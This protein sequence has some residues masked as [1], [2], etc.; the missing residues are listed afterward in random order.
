M[1][2]C[3]NSSHDLNRGLSKS[4]AR[5]P[6]R[7]LWVSVSG[8]LALML[9]A[10]MVALLEQTAHAKGCTAWI[11]P[12]PVGDNTNEGT[13]DEPWATLEH[14]ARNV[15]DEGC[16][17]WVE[18]GTYY[19][20]T[21]F[22]RRFEQNVT[23]KAAEPYEVI[24][25]NRG[26]VLNFDGALNVT[27]EGFV[28]R[29]S[30]PGAGFQVIKIDRSADDWSE[31]I[32][33][34]NNIL[35]D[36]Y[37]DD[38]LKIYN[39]VRF[40]TVE[41]NIFFNQASREEHIDINSVTDIT[42]Q[43]NIF[44]N[45]FAGSGRTNAQD[46]K[47]FITI[48]DSNGDDDDQVGSERITVQRNVFLNWQGGRE[49]FIQVGNDGKPYF[50]ARE[51]L[52]ANNL[53]I[54]N[55]PDPVYAPIGVR[56]VKDLL[57]ANNTIV[58]DLPGSS[59]GMWVSVKDKNPINEDV[60]FVN[61]IWSDPTGTM[62]ADEASANKFSTGDK[63]AVEGLILDNNLYWNGERKVPAG[64]LVSPREDDE[65][66]IEADPLL[67][68]DQTDL[69]LPHWDGHAFLS[70]SKSIRHEFIRL[71]ETYGRTTANSP[72]IAQADPQW[73]PAED[74]LGRPRGGKP[75]MGAYEYYPLLSGGARPTQILLHWPDFGKPAVASYAISYTDGADEVVIT[76]IDPDTVAYTLT[77]LA[78]YV[79]YS[80]VVTAYDE[81]ERLLGQSTPLVLVTGDDYFCC[82]LP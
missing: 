81:D 77:N 76:D 24:L 82:R 40:V 58:G 18:P 60:A 39:G 62:G 50:E 64:D 42:I 32:V 16:T 43:D 51:V 74:I 72:G 35:H 1:R 20:E 2:H 53:L 21:H 14:A 29:H 41:H 65:R 4:H 80:I 34:R 28:I 5:E 57:F 79:Q 27:I 73:T 47:S 26:T 19:G 63:D 38:L 49:T 17:V 7:L 10:V 61:N 9:V 46:T 11:A 45:D 55:G 23:F 59:F 3:T 44:F 31:H 52:I 25:E 30:G 33:F 48:K 78:P 54:G 67:N 69:I 36:S 56:G 8:L 37:N 15:P 13:A 68:T 66:R 71:V 22:V 70:G 6:M 75:D 12:Y